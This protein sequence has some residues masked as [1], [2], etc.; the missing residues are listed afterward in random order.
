M[1]LTSPVPCACSWIP[2]RSPARRPTGALGRFKEG[3]VAPSL[4]CYALK[5]SYD[6]SESGQKGGRTTSEVVSITFGDPPAELFEVPANY[7]ERKPSE[8]MALRVQRNWGSNARPT[9]SKPVPS[10]T[11]HTI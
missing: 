3:W 5:R 8:L 4:G 9:C 2:S 7:T 6:V 11:R 1:C 10:W